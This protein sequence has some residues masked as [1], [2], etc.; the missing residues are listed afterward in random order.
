MLAAVSGTR[1][2]L[3]EK[4]T[5]SGIRDHS[6]QLKHI[7]RYSTIFFTAFH[8]GL[9]FCSSSEANLHMLRWSAYIGAAGN[10]VGRFRIAKSFSTI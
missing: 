1:E 10:S 2:G 4:G 8:T 6:L 5:Q 9:Y 7:H 3:N